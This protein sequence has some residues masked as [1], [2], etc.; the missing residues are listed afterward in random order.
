MSMISDDKL[1]SLSSTVTGE[2]INK[3]IEVYNLLDKS[4]KTFCAS[5]GVHCTESCGECC[6]HY[7]PVLT[8]EE[9]EVAAWFIINENRESE[10]LASLDAADKTSPG[11]PLYNKDK[12]EH[13]SLYEGRSMVCRLFGSAVTLDKNGDPVYKECKWKKEKHSLSQ[14]ELKKRKDILPVMSIYGENLSGDAESIYTALPKAI[15]KIKLLLSYS[16][17]YPA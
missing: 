5:F 8:E 7:L 17:S 6:C 11:C 15:N 16:D 12:A 13:C 10:I 9:A 14:E 3:L 1:S 2:R 4:E